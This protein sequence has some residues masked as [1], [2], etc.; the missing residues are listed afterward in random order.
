MAE[1]IL[2]STDLSLESLVA[3]KIAAE[4]QKRRHAKVTLLHVVEVSS[5]AVMPVEFSSPW[6]D[7]E[8]VVSQMETRG[9]NRLNEIAKEF[10]S[11]GESAGVECKVIRGEDPVYEEILHYAAEEKVSLII[12]GKH[13]RSGLER[14]FLGSVTNK[15]IQLA[16]CP[17]LVVPVQH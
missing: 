10:F 12:M 1:H 9:K 15:V 8:P 16:P 11:G 6:V 4:E 7:I 3:M 2:V 13:G 17:V 14:L 5:L